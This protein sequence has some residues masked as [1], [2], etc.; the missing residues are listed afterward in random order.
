MR[1]IAACAF[2]FIL[3]VLAAVPAYAATLDE[4]QS[5]TI[6]ADTSA[7]GVV[8]LRYE[9]VWKVLDST[10]EGPLTWVQI[11]V[12][13]DAYEITDFGGD[14]V[15]AVPYNQADES[16]VRLDLCK[17]FLAGETA[18][19]HF[20]IRQYNLLQKAG[21][22]CRCDFIPGWF[23]DIAVK[24]MTVRW[25]PGNVIRANK[26]LDGV[27]TWSGSL[28]AGE[29]FQTVTTYYSGNMA[30]AAPPSP[31][32]YDY[33][34]PVDYSNT[35]T[36]DM[37]SENSGDYSGLLAFLFLPVVV[38]L[39]IIRGAR[40]YRGG[41]GF[42]GGFR[43]GGGCACAC[44]GCACACACAGGGR[45]GCARKDFTGFTKERED[46]EVSGKH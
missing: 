26:T 32:D 12:P 5:V 42:G 30:L 23:D 46:D 15:S 13:N 2:L 25:Q 17:D 9:I 4:I 38:V 10:S 14:A 40:G 34:P 18:A 24:Q 3:L 19:F 28:A 37:S 16:K 20:T 36:E 27:Y 22:E 41:R 31:A 11:G 21:N 29:H 43:G 1:R 33:N 39:A 45:A 35:D 8:T 44:A 6:D 7:D